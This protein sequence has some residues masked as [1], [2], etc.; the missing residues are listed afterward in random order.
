MDT[1]DLFSYGF[2][3]S[4]SIFFDER[5]LP[6]ISILFILNNSIKLEV[7]SSFIIPFLK[8]LIKI[9]EIIIT[10]RINRYL[11]LFIDRKKHPPINKELNHYMKYLVSLIT[12]E[13]EKL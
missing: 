12:R 10:N 5:S 9:M 3:T 11:Y 13:Q 1:S 4:D 7:N 6:I 2:K 8:K